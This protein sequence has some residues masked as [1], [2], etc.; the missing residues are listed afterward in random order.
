MKYVYP[1]TS[2]LMKCFNSSYF[3]KFLLKVEKLVLRHKEYIYIYIFTHK[4]INAN[5]IVGERTTYITTTANM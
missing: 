5:L 2:P 1:F 3:M 4:S